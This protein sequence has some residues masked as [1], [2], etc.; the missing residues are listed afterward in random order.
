MYGFENE[1]GLGSTNSSI[2][3]IDPRRGTYTYY[4]P[5]SRFIGSMGSIQQTPFVVTADPNGFHLQEV[6]LDPDGTTVSEDL[7]VSYYVDSN[8]QTQPLSHAATDN[9][10]LGGIRDYSDVRP[11]KTIWS[12]FSVIGTFNS[13]LS[14]YG[15]FTRRSPV[16]IGL[17]TRLRDRT[18]S[19]SGQI[20]CAGPSELVSTD[21]DWTGENAVGCTV[22]PLRQ[23]LWI[24]S[25]GILWVGQ[26]P[27][28]NPNPNN[29]PD[30]I[31]MSKVPGGDISSRGD[32]F[33]AVCCHDGQIYVSSRTDLY[34]Y[35]GES[36]VD[37]V[38]EPGTVLDITQLRFLVND[39]VEQAFEAAMFRA[40]LGNIHVGD[41]PETIY[42]DHPEVLDRLAIWLTESTI[43]DYKT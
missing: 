15:V 42:E 36:V 31:S 3:T 2:W 39:L 14:R 28:D 40:R 33:R 29:V 35:N 16:D 24:I 5:V 37:D 34:W 19:Y 6:L 13:K 12:D 18:R 7:H 1:S 9:M 8:S 27:K 43:P 26:L 11:S 17:R 32:S 30:S 21:A 4:G 23:Q 20:L 41:R 22:D 38:N 25:E 10:L